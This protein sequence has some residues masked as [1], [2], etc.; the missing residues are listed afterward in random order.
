MSVLTL[1]FYVEFDGVNHS[2]LLE[3]LTSLHTSFLKCT[4]ATHSPHSSQCDLLKLNV[5]SSHLLIRILLQKL[6]IAL[7]IKSGHFTKALHDQG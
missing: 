2:F 6:P 7:G 1:Y 5:I 3:T 4:L